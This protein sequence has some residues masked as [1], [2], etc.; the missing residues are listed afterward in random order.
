MREGVK[1][2]ARM[3]MLKEKLTEDSAKRRCLRPQ[4]QASDQDRVSWNLKRS[5]LFEL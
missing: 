4:P 3:M 5:L 2:K 1:M